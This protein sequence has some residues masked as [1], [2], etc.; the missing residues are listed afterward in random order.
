MR[1]LARF[2]LLIVALSLSATAAYGYPTH[3]RETYRTMHT[4]HFRISYPDPYRFPALKTAV[5]AEEVFAELTKRLQWTPNTPIDIVI[6][7]RTDDANGWSS[8]SPIQM[9]HLYLAPPQTGD[10]LDYYDDWLRILI[11]HEMTHSIHIDAVRAIPA[12]WRTVFGR[13]MPIGHYQPISLIEGIAVH[14]ET[15]LTTRGRARSPHSMMLLRMAAL[16]DQWPTIDRI[17]SYTTCYP[18]GAGSYIWGGIFHQYLASRFGEAALAEYNIKHSGQIWPFLFNHN[19]KVIFGHKLTDLYQEWSAEMMAQFAKQRARIEAEGLTE[20]I[21]LT[22]RGYFHARPRWISPHV[23]VYEERSG[24]RS[25]QLRRIDVRNKKRYLSTQVIKTYG[26]S[27]WTVTADGS[28][29]YSDRRPHDRWHVAYDLWRKQPGH[30][31][32]ERLTRLARLRDPA[33]LPGSSELVV[34]SQ[35]GGRSRLNLYDPQSDRLTPLTENNAWDDYVQFNGPTPHPNGEWLA[36]SVWH[37]DG[38]RDIFGFD[39]QTKTFRRL[40]AHPE[41]DID[42][43]FSPDGRWLLFSSGRSG[44]YNIYAL[45]LQSDE[46]FRVTNVLGGAFMPDVDPSGKRLVYVGYNAGGFDVYTMPFHPGDWVKIE[47]ENIESDAIVMGAIARDLHE[48]ARQLDPP[49]DDYSPWRTIWPHWWLP[50]ISLGSGGIGLGAET[51]GVDALAQHAWNLGAVYSLNRQFVHVGAGYSYSGITP[52]VS[53]NVYRTAENHGE[54][55]LDEDG[56]PVDYW[57][58]RIGGQLMT[59]W[60][61]YARHFLLLGY[62]GQW[63]DDL[64]EVDERNP[65]VPFAGYWSGLRVGWAYDSTRTYQQSV[66]NYDGNAFSVAATFYDP[67]FGS[68]AAQQVYAASVSQYVPLFFRNHAL[69]FHLRGGL[70]YGELI[71]QRSFRLGGWNVSNI[72]DGATRDERFALRG[73]D[74]GLGRGDR[75]GAGTL[76]YHLPLARIN[77]GLWTWPIFLQGINMAAF[78][79]G[80]FAIDSDESLTEDELYP[81]VGSEVYLDTVLA[82]YYVIRIRTGVA[83]GLRDPDD[84][85]GFHWLVTLGGL[86]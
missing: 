23:I 39:L 53:L 2:A 70:S 82:Y 52:V 17:S 71:L 62:L 37:D 11:T 44:V 58:H 20:P 65:E 59:A 67:A 12:A 35:N 41:R 10:R 42:P 85:G 8:V 66:G 76:E 24:D 6:S 80:G 34:V 36:V 51:G 45:D 86:L 46:L 83:Y 43:A 56:E 3:P 18:G 22:N 49:T 50:D 48:R 16:E 32:P 79:E 5:I 33:A 4:E 69:A 61:V 64:E 63:R 81:T 14:E 29:I 72:L 19:A 74:S 54:I 30:T 40:T 38:N 26:A 15:D 78:G 68:A 84:G 1:L 57:E 21:R 25:P 7:D 27:G 13:T 9:I 55:I 77:R 60:P 31:L 47:R 75:A 28:L 73:Y